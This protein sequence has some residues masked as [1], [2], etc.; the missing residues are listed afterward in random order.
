[1]LGAAG[2]LGAIS[3]QVVVPVLPLHLSKIGY[4]PSQIGT[5]ISLLSL[6]MGLVEL[7][8]G[9]IVA[10]F[11][12]RQTLLG[13]LLAN[14]VCMVLVAEARMALLVGSALA[15][16]GAARAAFWP[17]LHATVADTAS[18]ETRGRAF[19]IFW[20]W[21]SVAFLAGPAIG[22][23]TAARYGDPAAFYL[24]AALSLLALPVII[25][26]TTP[27][28]PPSKVVTIGVGD[29][30]RDA[31]FLRLCIVNHLYYGMV[32]IWIIFLPLY[33]AQQG[34]SVVIV[35]L[36]LT[37]QGFTY[38]L[39]Q[40]PAGRLADQWGPERLIL[41]AI[42]GRATIPLLVPLFHLHTPA[43]FLVAGAFYGLT[44]GMIPVTFTAL[45]ARQVPRDKYTSAMGVYNSSGD[46]GIF[47]GPLLGGVAAL[48]GIWAPF[49]LSAPIG[50]AAVMIGLSGMAAAERSQKAV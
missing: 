9:R 31:T 34:L 49:L 47:V 35:G 36:V 39:V 38:A 28:P 25:A 18:A 48:L 27:Q 19:G 12:R 44:G 13:G 16:V 26:V 30:L 15:A 29:V 5:L 17:P 24:G 43:A 32:G 41:P 20:F 37:V 23:V 11:G 22:G 4:S 42:I 45:I 7:Q 14:A 46:L 1:M 3:W 21:T 8:V 2:F 10:V 40:I 50:I 33:M 6:A